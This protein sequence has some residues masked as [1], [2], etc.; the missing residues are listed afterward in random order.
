MD[1]VFNI[2]KHLLSALILDNDIYAINGYDVNKNMP[3]LR[4][5]EYFT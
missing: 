2:Y 3:V 4:N 5:C 1:N